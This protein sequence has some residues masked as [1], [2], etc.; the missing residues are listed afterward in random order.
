MLAISLSHHRLRLIA[1]A[2]TLSALLLWPCHPLRAQ[3]AGGASP[4]S[5]AEIQNSL[6]RS[7]TLF[8]SVRETSGIPLSVPAIVRVSP[9][10]GGQSLVASVRENS[11]ATFSGVKQ[12]DYDV[13]VDAPG[14]Q[15]N[16]ERISVAGVSA[17]TAYIYLTPV[18]VDISKN[19]PAAGTVM[20]PDLQR[21]LDR[22]FLALN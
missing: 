2:I 18:G 14:Y 5:S 6:D 8:V 12:G 22:A 20:T 21:L 15:A 3:L 19:K 10:I 17:Y 9:L 7:L 1:S 16:T 4:L 11:S 13:Q